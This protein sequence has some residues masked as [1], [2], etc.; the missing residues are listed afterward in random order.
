MTITTTQKKSA[1]NIAFDQIPNTI[2]PNTTELWVRN[3]SWLSLPSMNSGDSKFVGLVAIYPDTNNGEPSNFLALN[4]ANNY[5]VDWG[6]GVVENFNSGVSSYHIYDYTNNNLINTNAPITF[7]DSGDIIQ[8][9]GHGYSDGMPV[10]F[11]SIINTSGIT[12]GQTYYVVNS[13]NNNFQITSGVGS[14]INLINDGSGNLLRYKQAIVTV[15]PQSGQNLTALNLNIKHNQSTLQTYT[16]PWL[17]IKVSSP[18]LTSL[19][20]HNF[21]TA[22]V[23]NHYLL[24]QIEILNFG[25]I[26]D[27]SNIFNNLVFLKS[28]KLSNTSNCTNMQRM[29]TNCASLRT[30][31]TFN[32]SSCTNM[33]FMFDNCSG[34]FSLSNLEVPKL[35]NI[36]SMFSN[37]V[38]LYYPPLFNNTIS[39]ISIA[40]RLF[41]NCINLK[42]TPLFDTTQVTNTNF[43]FQGCNNLR[44]I[45][46]YNFQNVSGANSMFAGCTNLSFVPNLNLS[47]VRDM[48]V[49]FSGCASLKSIPSFDTQATTGMA[50]MFFNCSDLLSVPLLN[51]SGVTSMVNTF[52]GCS[53]LLSVPFFDTKN[54]T[55]TSNMFLNC[56]SLKSIPHFNTDSLT[57]AA[58]MFNG[59]ISLEY[60]PRLSF[61]VCTSLDNTFRNCSRLST[62]PNFDISGVRSMVNTFLNCTSL[63]SISLYWA[64]WTSA[65]GG[66]DAFTSAFQGCTSLKSIFFTVDAGSLASAFNGCTNLR[67]V[68]GVNMARG[69]STPSFL[70]NIFANCPNFSDFEIVSPQASHSIANCKLSKQALNKW[71]ENATAAFGSPT[72]TISNNWGNLAY[73]K[74]ISSTAQSNILTCSNTSLLA[75]GMSMTGT[76]ASIGGCV[77]V[78]DIT[79][80]TI[81]LNNH[82]LIS[83]TRLSFSSLGTTTGFTA[84][85]VVYPINITTN[86]F[87]ISSTSG[88]S[89]TNLTGSNSNMTMRYDTFISNITPSS[90]IL[91]LPACSSI[92]S[93]TWTFRNINPYKALHQN[94]GIA[95]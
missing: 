45:P 88:G 46:A 32:T 27:L 31:N 4:A 51:T 87:Q 28:I 56:V 15:T 8:S 44:S 69:S 62:V 58:G 11:Y 21:P 50:N 48:S 20:F 9:S 72:M 89:A 12:E 2:F 82:G 43:M 76:G 18:N 3:P 36:S 30:I 23:V 92:T 39:G 41:F 84:N 70:T 77:V 7:L 81:T 25:N 33:S 19:T 59:C 91:D 53:G 60:I 95:Y 71:F 29:F 74:T 90:I 57:T 22:S 86:T 75:S 78:S 68:S 24:E 64:W 65:I 17:D 79:A 73:P 10:K 67:Y 35:T 93:G 6:D 83:G 55:S 94:W 47:K 5:T 52:A 16:T 26:T 61:R 80:D 42:S 38:S 37:C 13:T 49:M 85:R 1:Y 63:R 40:D 66:V 54:V 34:L 14:A